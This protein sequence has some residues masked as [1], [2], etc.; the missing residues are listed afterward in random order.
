MYSDMLNAKF[1]IIGKVRK[2]KYLPVGKQLN[3]DNVAIP[4]NILHLLK[5]IELD[6]CI[7]KYKDLQT[8]LLR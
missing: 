8:K 7:Q 1:F 6:L 3:K 4:W 5:K 2:G